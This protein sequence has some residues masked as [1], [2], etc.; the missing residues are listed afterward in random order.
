MRQA[1]VGC[2]AALAGRV[3]HQRRL[4]R[5]FYRP[6]LF[7]PGNAPRLEP[8]EGIADAAIRYGTEYKEITAS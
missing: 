8:P 6:L 4:S 1:R 3:Q 7:H 2:L 5:R